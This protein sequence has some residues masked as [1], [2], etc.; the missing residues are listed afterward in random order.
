VGAATRRFSALLN[1]TGKIAG[2]QGDGETLFSFL[3][4]NVA[5]ATIS[6]LPVNK[7]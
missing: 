6:L 1:A 4:I 2:G 5:M 3:K 7:L